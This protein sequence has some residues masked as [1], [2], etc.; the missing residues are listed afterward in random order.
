MR[1]CRPPARPR[2]GQ[3]RA[4]LGSNRPFWL[5]AGTGLERAASLIAGLGLYLYRPFPGIRLAGS[6]WVAWNAYLNTAA[7]GPGGP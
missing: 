5:G 2:E 6:R 1:T 4:A 7:P 3:A